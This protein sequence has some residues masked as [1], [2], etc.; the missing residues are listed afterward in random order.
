MEP[1]SL[2]H[3]YTK[4]W[5][6]Q[7]IGAPTAVQESAWPL[8]AAGEATLVSAPTGTGKTLSSFLVFIDRLMREALNGTLKK[9]L[10][11]IYVSPLKSLAGDIRENL[12]RPLDGIAGVAKNAGEALSDT[13]IDIAIRTGDTTQSERRRM[14]KNP[15]HIL[16]TT[17]ESLFLM[18]TAMSSQ[19]VISTAKWI[20]IDELHALIDTKRGAH[21][22]LSIARLDRL[23]PA[24]LQRIGLSATIEPL[25]VAAEY[26]SPER[27]AIAAPKMKKLISLQVTSPLPMGAEIKKNNAWQEIAKT[28]LDRCGSSRSVIAFVEGRAYAERLAYHVNEIAGE[29]FA[30]TH[31]GSMSKE[32]RLEVEHALRAGTLR[33]LCATS[34]M[35]LGIDV[36]EIDHVF[37]VGCPRTVSSTM[38]RLGRAGHNP[39]R[40]SSMH[41]FPRTPV[42]GLYSGL[43]CEVVKLGGVEHSH[44]PRLCLDVL[45][46]HL[47]SMAAGRGYELSE[48]L[49]ILKRAWPFRDV[50]LTD[51]RETLR[52]LAGDY[53]HDRDIPVR[54]RILYDRIHDRVEPDPYSRMLAV[55]AGGTIP[56]KGLYTAKTES[57]VTLGE[58]D[59]EF[60]YESRVGD[61]FLLGSFAWKITNIQKDTVTVTPA[62][63]QGAR[64]PF[65]K[66]EI[67]G[68]SLKT[69]LAF[70]SI[71]R[72]LTKASEAG[73]LLYELAKLDLDAA[74]AESAAEL[75]KRQISATGA[76]PDDRTIIVEHYRDEAGNP[77][78]MVHSVF[79]R[80]VN[81]PLA[82]L[83]AEA[84][85]Q[86]TGMNVNYVADDDGILLFPY[87]DRLLP[88][89][90]L[91]GISP[92][93][94]AAVLN[95][96]LPASQVYNMA[97][98]YNAARA[99]MMGMKNAG[100]QPLW[101][102]RMR[103]AQMLD[104][105]VREHGHPI[106]RETRREC[107]EDY[108]DVE[109]VKQILSQIR[110]GEI[111]VVE[112]HQESPSPLSLT[113]RRQTEA[114][115]M[116]E[117]FPTPM[118]TQAAVE[119][120]LE[121]AQ[122]L[123]PEEGALKRVAERTK[124]PENEVQ[125]HSLL[126][127][128]G[129]LMPGEL[130]I[131]PEWLESLEEKGRALFIE[132]GL[133]IAAE[134]AQQYEAALP[135]GDMEARNQV[136][137]RLLRYRGP[138]A[139]WE[140]AQRYG[141][142]EEA[143]QAVLASLAGGGEAVEREG[144]YY[145]GQLYERAV[146]ETV[147][148]RRTRIHT[149]PPERYAALLASRA[150]RPAPP[151][152]QLEEALK[153]LCGLYFPAAWWESLLLP[154]RVGGYRPEMLDA[155]LS[156]G[157]IFW[158]MRESGELGF[159]LYEDID[160]EKEL[161]PALSEPNERE[162]LLLNALRQRG[163]SFAHS[164]SSL[165]GEA[166]VFDTLIGL[167][168]KGLTRAD[169]F[170]PVRQWLL[171]EQNTQASLRRKVNARVIATT[172]GRWE[173]M[174]PLKAL[175]MEQQLMR[176]FDQTA[177]LCRETA[178]NLNW[179]E[180]VK[181]LRLWEYT[182]RVRRGYFIE[183]MSG[184]QFIRD[185]DY[186]GVTQAMENPDRDILWL[187]AADPMQPYG[188]YLPH[189]PDR[190]FMNLPGNLVA[191]MGGMPVMVFERHGK[192]LRVF[193]AEA[194]EA[195]LAA[196]AKEYAARR[197]F[198]ALSRITLKEY[199]K[200]AADSLQK[201]GFKREMQDFVL[202]R[203]Y[204]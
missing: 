57:G 68:R 6:E 180:A 107:L 175:S 74:A 153:S 36:G 69:G 148:G 25:S 32:H 75:V 129:D 41:I 140:M 181:L 200:E 165:M 24:P 163:A 173:L 3:P 145:H 161:E 197:V 116:Y 133:W 49:E 119:E 65:W 67:K 120:A 183:G 2:F 130:D 176:A 94:A 4:K 39:N 87:G 167:A 15:P 60:I 19:A 29:G 59:E 46:Q 40:I 188:K 28:I 73:K 16:I 92:D 174:R 158:R 141:L 37:Q 121:K 96:M 64:L 151:K 27:A 108:W 194:M 127:I 58:L 132:P 22:M 152:E 105:L 170:V 10:Q 23:C 17:P 128:E 198:S 43:T 95:A 190:P 86:K 162:K 202:Y 204:V 125:L 177:V 118:R 30:R 47:V 154:L 113:L 84:A 134:Q 147:M 90:L 76:L 38:Q 131:P 21:L 171:A 33:L 146:R 56:D 66:G 85:R 42:E 91:T 35:E 103:S 93:G 70:G 5:F 187:P 143:A 83:A 137:R 88:Q 13:P 191:L 178:Q 123:P 45:A 8:I 9:E 150:Q 72:R 135:G 82:M 79:G 115:M 89:K 111:R 139:V 102:Q 12:R 126:M 149:L 142:Q 160:W 166:S 199:P 136:F 101:V 109:G 44:P 144:L 97:F 98:R 114:S 193:D 7:A 50:T 61:R 138:K 203:G 63:P 156:Q 11:L 157:H 1:L 179:G 71:L 122:L 117:Y 169:S 80:P 159:H 172:S 31:H 78:M 195:G 77:Q 14:L 100:R 48:V 110:S 26:L 20:I 52:M 112:L 104:T 185:S 62:N 196:F 201:A 186:A 106:V 189:M 51:V 53:E 99:L 34:S 55:S 168:S 81:E 124:L 54:P 164:L 18:L 192:T 182:G 155:I 184:M